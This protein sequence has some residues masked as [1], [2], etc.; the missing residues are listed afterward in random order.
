MKRKVISERIRQNAG[1]D[2][3]FALLHSLRNARKQAV[4]LFGFIVLL[5]GVILAICGVCLL[6]VRHPEAAIICA[7]V[8]A[9]L[10]ALWVIAT[11]DNLSFLQATAW[12]KRIQKGDYRTERDRIERFDAKESVLRFAEA[13]PFLIRVPRA[14]KKDPK[15]AENIAAGLKGDVLLIAS[16]DEY[17]SIMIMEMPVPTDRTVDRIAEEKFDGNTE[18]AIRYAFATCQI[19]ELSRFLAQLKVGEEQS[20]AHQCMVDLFN[21]EYPGGYRTMQEEFAL[22]TKYGLTRDALKAMQRN[23][24]KNGLIRAAVL[25]IAVNAGITAISVWSP[26]GGPTDAA[27]ITTLGIV[28]TFVVGDLA[29]RILRA[30]RIGKLL[31]FYR[32]DAYREQASRVSEEEALRLEIIADTIYR[33]RLDRM[34]K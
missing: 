25:A 20:F 4:V 7:A 6:I 9:C 12:L 11:R 24:E 16:G 23:P 14:V 21:Q 31:R 1:D 17:L 15:L 22:A 32:S 18:E 3:R 19:G 2:P 33:I 30:R 27:I 5:P 28:D 29:L 10:T 26:F 34:A 8:F 13:G